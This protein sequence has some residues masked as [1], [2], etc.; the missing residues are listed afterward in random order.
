MP[1]FL[2]EENNKHAGTGLIE[3]VSEWWKKH[4]FEALLVLSIVLI[5]IIALVRIG[6]KG[7]WSGGILSLSK[8]ENTKTSGSRGWGNRES[9][10]EVECRSVLETHFGKPFSKARPSLLRN[11]VTKNFNLELDCYN[12]E[13]GIACEYNGSQHYKYTPYF[14]RNHDAFQN[15]Q[16]RD[17]LKRRICAD[18]GIFLIEVPYTVKHEHIKKFILQKLSEKK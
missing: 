12:S 14:H 9:K 3:K 7:T 5:I 8:A 17:E 4:G 2:K 15:Q 6:K 13:L 11:P 1:Q 16:Y 10:G 18:N